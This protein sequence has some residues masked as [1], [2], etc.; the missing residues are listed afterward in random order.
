MAFIRFQSIFCRRVIQIELVVKFLFLRINRRLRCCNNFAFKIA[1]ES[2]AS[3]L[4]YT[5][6]EYLL[7]RFC[8]KFLQFLPIGRTWKDVVKLPPP[9]RT[10]FHHVC[11]VV[12]GLIINPHCCWLYKIDE[13]GNFPFVGLFFKEYFSSLRLPNDYTTMSQFPAFIWCI[14]S[15]K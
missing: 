2:K 15:S 5:S 9:L 11:C 8:G 13:L 12:M 10:P 1:P 14:V 4:L 3:M 6:K 7:Y